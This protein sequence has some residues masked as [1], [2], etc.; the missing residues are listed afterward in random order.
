MT[1]ILVSFR[2]TNYGLITLMIDKN[3]LSIGN[4]V[5]PKIK[6]NQKMDIESLSL[7]TILNIN[8]T[9]EIIDCNKKTLD[10]LYG[11]TLDLN[12]SGEYTFFA[13][14]ELPNGKKIISNKL[15]SFVQKRNIEFE[16][17][18]QNKSMLQAV[19]SLS[20]GRYFQVKDIDS[21]LTSTQVTS[22]KIN[23]NLNISGISTQHYWW[24]LIMALIFEWFIRKRLGLL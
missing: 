20:G 22:K 23:K 3:S 5:T 18:V 10:N 15:K 1:V 12:K 7:F 17:L 9:L 8:D 13:Q 16:N 4:K 14:V 24:F 11:C 2:G 6:I 19:S 21:I